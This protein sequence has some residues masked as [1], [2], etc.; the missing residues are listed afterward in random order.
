MAET[1]SNDR[2]KVEQLQSYLRVI[3]KEDERIPLLSTDGIYGERTKAAVNE[4]Q[5][6]NSFPITGEVN[7]ETWNE[8]YRQFNEIFEKNRPARK[9]DLF[10]YP[11]ATLLLGQS[12]ITIYFV[13]TMILLISEIFANIE[14]IDINGTVD[15][16]TV[17]EIDK[18]K[19]I[20][21]LAENTD[22]KFFFDRLSLLYEQAMLIKY[23]TR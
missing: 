20:F 9:V 7:E 14:K 16:A 13:Q 21:D 10:R 17:K 8:I 3:A 15:E 22:D 11:D 19:V 18:L 6:I 2:R 12:G 5:R 1:Q 4:F 23:E